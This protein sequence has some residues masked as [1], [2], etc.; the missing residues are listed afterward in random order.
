MRP[1]TLAS[2][3]FTFL[4]T[5][6]TCAPTPQFTSEA[7]PTSDIVLRRSP[8]FTAEDAVATRVARQ[9]TAERRQFTAEGLDAPKT[10]VKREP[11]FTAE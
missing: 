9:F 4:I 2:V 3:L 5:L 8:Q 1:F 6:A 7:L 11:Q 10:V